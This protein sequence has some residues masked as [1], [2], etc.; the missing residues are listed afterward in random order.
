MR[1][2]KSTL[3]NNSRIGIKNNSTK[4]SNSKPHNK[5]KALTDGGC[6]KSLNLKKR[7]IIKDDGRYLI[8]YDF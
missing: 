4:K 2:E 1:K 3:N 5:E 7:V 6:G 8:Y